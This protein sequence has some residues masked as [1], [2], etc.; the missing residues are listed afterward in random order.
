MSS[1]IRAIV[2]LSFMGF[3]GACERSGVA[4]VVYVDEP[5]VTVEPVYTGKYK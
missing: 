2:A 1:T 3:L 4:E 5:M